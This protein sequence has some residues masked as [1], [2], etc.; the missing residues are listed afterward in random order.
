MFADPDGTRYGM[1]ATPRK[2]YSFPM[3]TVLIVIV[4]AVVGLYGMAVGILTWR[5]RRLVYVPDTN[6]PD[7]SAA[8]VPGA[9]ETTVHTGDGLDLLAWQVAAAD[10]RQPVVL[11]LHGNGGHIGYRTRRF[12][13]LNRLG[14]GVLL[15]EY[16]GYGGNAGSPTE[17]GLIEDARAGYAALVASGI[18]ARRIVLWGESLGSG[19]AVRL[20]AEMEVG[21]VLLEAPYTSIAAIARQRFPFV[22]VDWLLWDRFDLIG[23]IGSVDAPVLVMAGV[24]DIIVPPAM[25]QAVFAAANEPKVFWLAPDAGHNDLVEAGAFDVAQAFVREHWRAGP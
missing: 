25:S 4:L 17:T 1:I 23:R 9:H 20:A 12:A 10:D 7:L 16:R 21:A 14:W 8:E 2:D 15:L 13:T 11:Y 24:Q 19:V 6:L 22:P 18:P 3:K 5:Q